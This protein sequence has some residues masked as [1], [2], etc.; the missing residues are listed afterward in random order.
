MPST[1]EK[2]DHAAMARNVTPLTE[3][4]IYGKVCPSKKFYFRSGVE[5]D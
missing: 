5:E 1:D 3:L 2:A 4:A